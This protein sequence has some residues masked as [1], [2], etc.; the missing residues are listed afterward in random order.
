MI[1]MSLIRLTY[2]KE[3]DDKI[4]WYPILAIIVVVWVIAP[5]ATIAFS[6]LVYSA[7]KKILNILRSRIYYLI[8]MPFICGAIFVV[9][10]SFFFS[11]KY[12]EDMELKNKL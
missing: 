9:Y 10:A 6:A 4:C 7:I 5:L 3:N 8:V 12:F 1:G 2:L 11:T